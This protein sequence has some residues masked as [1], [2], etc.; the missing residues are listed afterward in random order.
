MSK[1][2]IKAATIDDVPLILTFIKKPAEHEKLAHM[3]T[4]TEEGL[5]EALFG[6]RQ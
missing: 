3:V 4:A 6:A 5:R 2:T 1:F